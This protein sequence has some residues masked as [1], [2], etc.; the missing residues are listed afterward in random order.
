[1]PFSPVENDG[2]GVTVKFSKAPNTKYTTAKIYQAEYS[3]RNGRIWYNFSHVNGDP[4]RNVT[5]EMWIGN[6][7]PG[8]C[9]VIYCASGSENCD[10]YA[11]A[12]L[13]YNVHNCKAD[14]VGICFCCTAG[15]VKPRLGEFQ[16][17]F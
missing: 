1:V 17:G 4:L 12:G 14:N 5:R 16:N 9:D 8:S 3:V 15:A 6:H 2:G 11:S 10:W 7:T 13:E